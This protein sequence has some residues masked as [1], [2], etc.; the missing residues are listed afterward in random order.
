MGY[1]KLFRTYV[2]VIETVRARVVTSQTFDGYVFEV[3]PGNRAALYRVD[4]NGFPRVDIVALSLV[5][6]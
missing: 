3:L 1:D 6:R 2:E 4:E 5:G